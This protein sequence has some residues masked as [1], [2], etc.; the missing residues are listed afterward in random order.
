MLCSVRPKV[1]SRLRFSETTLLRDREGLFPKGKLE[2]YYR[3]MG[4]DC[5][6]GKTHRCPL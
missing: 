3:R 1:G 2:G 5:W 4:T 6:L